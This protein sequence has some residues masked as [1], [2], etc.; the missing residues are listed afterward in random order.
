MCKLNRARLLV[1]TI[2][3]IAA[4]GGGITA[5]FAV[6]DLFAQHRSMMSAAI[7]NHDITKIKLLLKTNYID[8][9]EQIY[10]SSAI[11]LHEQDVV[12]LFLAAGANLFQTFP[13]GSSYLHFAILAG[14]VDMVRF[15]IAKAKAIPPT[16]SAAELDVTTFQH[17][18]NAPD[19]GERTPLLCV[20]LCTQYAPADR[21]AL[22]KLLVEN[23]AN[24]NF[25]MSNDQ[26]LIGTLTAMKG[27][28]QDRAYLQPYIR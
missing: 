19:A 21:L 2:C 8:V 16:W 13:N 24:P 20:V 1:V 15:L 18:I 25:T 28:E 12:T 3:L 22:I 5:A 9:D 6:P 10:L 23:G 27:T 17:W 7:K 26:N 11:G 4:A 14:D